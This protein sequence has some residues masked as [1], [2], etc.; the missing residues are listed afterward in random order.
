MLINTKEPD[1]RGTFVNVPGKLVDLLADPVRNRFYVLRQDRSLV[2]VF[3]GSSYSQIATLRTSMT[4]TSMAFTFDRKYLMVGHNDSHLAYVYDLDELQPVSPIIFPM[5]HYPRSLAASGK[6]ILAACRVAG[7]VHTIDRVDFANRTATALPS[8][9]IYKND[10]TRKPCSRPLP[11]ALPSWWPSRTATSCCMTPTPT[12]SPFR[13]RTSPPFR[14]RM[15]P[16]ATATTSSI[17]T[18]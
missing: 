9:G 12:P 17:T 15:R 11:T 4:P 3:D 5:G 8:L 1:Q 7:P 10:I 13:A 2:L 18:C 14:A 6:T 16:P